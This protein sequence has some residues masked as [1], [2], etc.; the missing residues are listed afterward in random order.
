MNVHEKCTN[1]VPENDMCLLYFT[2]GYHNVSQYK[3]CLEKQLYGDDWDNIDKCQVILFDQTS[4][5]F[6]AD[7]VCE[8]LNEHEAMKKFFISVAEAIKGD[9][10]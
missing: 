1:Y 4:G 9:E 2:F 8:M 7:K 6:H 10:K 5:L 3:E